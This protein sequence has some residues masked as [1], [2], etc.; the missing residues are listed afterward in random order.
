MSNFKKEFTVK[1]HTPMIHFQSDQHGATL[2]A[3][4]LKP[5]LDKFLLER[6][7]GIPFKENANGHKSLD[8]KVTIRY[9]GV[10]QFDY[11]KALVPRGES[12][13]VAPYF[14]NDGISIEG[15]ENIKLTFFSFNSSILQ[16]IADNIELF[17]AF[18]NFGTRQSKGFGSYHLETM[19]AKEFEQLLEKHENPTYK[20]KHGGSSPKDALKK[21]DNFYKKLKAGLNPR[22]NNQVPYKSLLFNYMCT[23]DKGWEKKWLKEN[24]PQIIYGDH[25]PYNC[26]PPSEFFYIRA[27]LGLAEHNEYSPPNQAKLQI[28]IKAGDNNSIERFKSPITFKIFENSIYLL[29]SKSYEEILNKEFIF[30]LGNTEHALFTPSVFSLENFLNYVADNENLLIRL[31]GKA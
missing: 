8:Y 9:K 7:E 17:F 12:G 25:E 30:R 1:Q 2:R 28:K 4:E 5:K 15:Q 20:L 3:T 27:V 6:V 19:T 24:F 23:E 10:N 13:Y 14:S 18:E 11:P 29:F 16:A 21:V 31:G 22:A 26:K